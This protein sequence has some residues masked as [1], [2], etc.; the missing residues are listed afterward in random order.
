MNTCD[1][2]APLY[3]KSMEKFRVFQ[4]GYLRGLES[5]EKM[6]KENIKYS[7]E[8]GLSDAWECARKILLNEEDGGIPQRFLRPLLG[9]CDFGHPNIFDVLRTMP[10]TE[11][12]EKITK[13]EESMSGAWRCSAYDEI[14]YDGN[15]KAIV[16]EIDNVG[17]L[18]IFNEDGMVTSHNPG[19][20]QYKKTGRR[21]PEMKD[22]L[23]K[24]REGGAND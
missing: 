13:Y 18:R 11:V 15:K 9:I 1:E 21:F 5:A 2:F 17:G 19:D 10:V 16:L 24:L 12:L 22:I 14:V 3:E 20:I 7:Y 6:A 4:N 23:D 8:Q